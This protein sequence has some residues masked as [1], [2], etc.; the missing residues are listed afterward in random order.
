[1][2]R[3]T[4]V[5]AYLALALLCAPAYA[6]DAAIEHV[7][8]AL[9]PMADHPSVV[10]ESMTVDVSLTVETAAVDCAFAFRNSGPSTTV[11]VGFPESHSG[12]VGSNEPGGF[13]TFKT[14]VDGKDV[15]TTKEGLRV[16]NDRDSW[17]RWRVKKVTFA[18]GQ[19]RHIRV[20]YSAP[21]GADITGNRFFSYRVG[22]GGSWKGPIGKVTVRVTVR[23]DPFDWKFDL[24]TRPE[25]R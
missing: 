19:T 24:E 21:T 5:L 17:Q 20:T 6:D 10:M 25:S 11:Q 23:Y 15:P 7:G 1:M 9:Q 8:G 18:A 13:T 16:S 4:R 12:E 22:T 14:W 3:S 2:T